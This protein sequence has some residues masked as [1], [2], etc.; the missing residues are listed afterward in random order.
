MPCAGM[1]LMPYSK[2]G[3]QDGS[4][5]RHKRREETPHPSLEPSMS[6]RRTL[7][8]V[9][10]VLLTPTMICPPCSAVISGTAT[11]RIAGTAVPFTSGQAGLVP[12]VLLVPVLPAGQNL[13]SSGVHL[14]CKHVCN[15]W[16]CTMK[17]SVLAGVV[18][19]CMDILML[20]RLRMLLAHAVC[21]AVLQMNSTPCSE[22]S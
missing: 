12:L 3:S 8:W 9:G 7:I 4:G 2:K 5:G 17:G 18:K 19:I 11:G 16:P 14:L 6:Q 13:G 22:A 20:R 1:M 10:T 15:V 21:G